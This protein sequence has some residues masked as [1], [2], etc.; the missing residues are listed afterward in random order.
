V[1]KPPESWWGGI[2]DCPFTQPVTDVNP[3]IENYILYVWLIKR[4]TD[5]FPVIGMDQG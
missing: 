3:V 1:T 4:I 2:Y 5:D